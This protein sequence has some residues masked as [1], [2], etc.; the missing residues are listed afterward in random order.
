MI[1]LIQPSYRVKPLFFLP[2]KIVE[3]Q[4]DR[5]RTLLVTLLFV[6]SLSDVIATVSFSK[7][8]KEKKKKK[9]DSPLPGH[10]VHGNFGYARDNSRV[11]LPRA[12][13]VFSR[14][15]NYGASNF[16]KL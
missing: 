7:E 8:I 3:T 4:E 6:S 15:G 14:A 9:E 2:F 13:D 16:T 10:L 5:Y 11:I 1:S 12:L